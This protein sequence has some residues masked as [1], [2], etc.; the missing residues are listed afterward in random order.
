MHHYLLFILAGILLNLTPGQD[1]LYV[2]GRSLSGGLRAGIAAALGIGV[3]SLIHTVA[4]ALGLSVV[5]AASPAAFMIVKLCGAAYLVFL[6][7]K[8]LFFRPRALA[9]P[10]PSERGDW[11]AFA[12]GILSNV[13]NPKVA[14]FFLAFL[15]QF[16]SPAST[17]KT[18]DFLA[19]GATFVTTGTIWC[20]I[21]AFA[22]ARLSRFF[23]A[24]PAVRTL[25]DRAAGALFIALGA[26]LA[27]AR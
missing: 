21:L 10:R 5:L 8:L 4:A 16:I 27:F 19:L 12:Q 13:L 17:S 2:L 24:N 25:I 9:A 7:A 23:A 1:T 3:G 20:L 14:L 26:R 15:P 6:G 11:S 22:A 18:L